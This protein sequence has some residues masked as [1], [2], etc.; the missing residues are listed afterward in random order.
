M[1]VPALHRSLG[2][3]G[4][5]ALLCSC[6]SADAGGRRAA[7]V[8][9]PP[10]YA[11]AQDCGVEHHE[12]LPHNPAAQD[13]AYEAQAY[14][15]LPLGEARTRAE[16]AGLALRVLGTDGD[17]TDR[18]DDLRSDRINLYVEDEVV[19]AAARF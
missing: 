19:R 3:L 9:S 14:V 18:T 12:H 10:A 1:T 7:G 13:P 4:L 2:A 8:G 17:C 6:G 11:W 15:G 5:L 16:G